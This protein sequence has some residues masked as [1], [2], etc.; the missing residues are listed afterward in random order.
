MV[1]TLEHSSDIG[2]SI[3]KKKKP[4]FPPELTK[5]SHLNFFRSDICSMNAVG[6]HVLSG[7]TEG[8]LFLWDLSRARSSLP[9]ATQ[10]SELVGKLDFTEHGAISSIKYGDVQWL[11]LGHGDGMISLLDMDVQRRANV[12]QGHPGAVQA[13]QISEHR[14]VIL[15][16]DRNGIVKVRYWLIEPVLHLING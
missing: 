8:N 10:S 16:G 2:T 4:R 3:K 5:I 9:W 12:L 13:I 15:S 14:G 6:H 11:A 7:D 1:N